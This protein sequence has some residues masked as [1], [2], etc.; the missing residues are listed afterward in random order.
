MKI[1]VLSRKVL[2]IV[3]LHE[4]EVARA[5]TLIGKGYPRRR[6]AEIINEQSRS[7]SH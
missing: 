2:R 7:Q 1:N 4:N 3:S 5:A 6:V